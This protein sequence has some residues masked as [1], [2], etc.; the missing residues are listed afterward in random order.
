MKQR[1]EDVAAQTLDPL[2]DKSRM[3]QTFLD[4]NRKYLFIHD[5]CPTCP[6]NSPLHQGTYLFYPLKD[7]TKGEQSGFAGVLLTE[8]LC[9]R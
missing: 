1:L 6:A 8:G 9:H 2:F 7:L 5:S 4:G 3:A